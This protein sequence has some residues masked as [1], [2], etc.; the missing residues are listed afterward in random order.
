MR[1]SARSA[2]TLVELL[3]VLAIIGILIALLLPAIQSVR[4]SARRRQC[5]NHL[6]QI[7]LAFHHHHDLHNAF[8]MGGEQAP[9]SRTWLATPTNL[10][11]VLESQY[12][13][14]AYQILPFIEQQS[15]WRERDNSVIEAT[16]LPLY[17]CPSRRR[18]TVV[19]PDAGGVDALAN[20]RAML[21]YAG[22][23]GTDG[24]NNEGYGRDGAVV[25]RQAAAVHFGSTIDGT[26]NTL[27]VGEKRLN[28]IR[29]NTFQHDDNEGWTSGW[30]WDAIRWANERP[31]PDHRDNNI[32]GCSGFGS[33]HPRS[34]NAA[35]CDGSV[36]AIGYAVEHESIRRACV[37][38][39]G[40]FVN[41]SGS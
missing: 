12:W 25:R 33:S 9:V 16:P 30:D 38:N 19:H 29:I 32:L 23:G 14:W 40:S 6:R 8:P 24:Q 3:V 27:L 1:Q 28:I 2:L 41:L 15:L 5:E 31:A 17:F 26:S 36:H 37:R 4:E 21:D 34:F 10:P 11:G 22:N 13:G 18:P 35:F 39:D 7:G 20:P